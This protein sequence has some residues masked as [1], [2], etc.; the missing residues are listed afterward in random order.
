MRTDDIS[1]IVL[2]MLRN[3]RL[4]CLPER[5]ILVECCQSVVSVVSQDPGQEVIDLHLQGC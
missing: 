1:G 2:L 4:I 5:M 3:A